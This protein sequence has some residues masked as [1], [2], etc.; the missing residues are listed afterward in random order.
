M[1]RKERKIKNMTMS[2][3]DKEDVQHMNIDMNMN[4]RTSM[5]MKE[6]TITA[7]AG[8]RR[9]PNDQVIVAP[10]HQIT[11]MNRDRLEAED[12]HTL[13]N[14]PPTALTTTSSATTTKTP[15]GTS[16]RVNN[17]NS[18]RNSGGTGACTGGDKDGGIE[19]DTDSKNVNSN[20]STNT[21]T[22]TNGNKNASANANANNSL[23]VNASKADGSNNSGP[24]SKSGLGSRNVVSSSAGSSSNSNSSSGDDKGP[25]HHNKGGMDKAGSS[26]KGGSSDKDKGSSSKPKPKVKGSKTTSQSHGYEHDNGLAH[27]HDHEH[28]HEHALYRNYTRGS[29]T[30][31][32]ETQAQLQVNANGNVNVNDEDQNPMKPLSENGSDGGY[33]G[34]A[35]SN[36]V[37]DNSSSTSDSVSSTEGRHTSKPSSLNA[38]RCRGGKESRYASSSS[39]LADFSSGASDSGDPN[40][41]EN[42]RLRERER[43]H[44]HGRRNGHENGHTHGR[45]N[46]Y[47]ISSQRVSSSSYLLVDSSSDDSASLVEGK[48]GKKRR[49]NSDRAKAPNTRTRTTPAAPVAT[50]TSMLKAVAKRRKRSSTEAETS[51]CDCDSS[52]DSKKAL[53]VG[54]KTTGLDTTR[55]RSESTEK[56]VLPRSWDFIEQRLKN[57]A[58]SL[59]D[60]QDNYQSAMKRFRDSDSNS[61][62]SSSTSNEKS[63]TP[64]YNIGVDVMAKILSYLKPMEANRVLSEPLSKTFR[65]SFSNPQDVWKILCLSEPF[66]ARVKK[67][68]DESDDSSSSYPICDNMELQHVLG[69][70]RL[71]YS[72]FVRCVTYLDRIKEDALNGNAP[73]IQ[74]TSKDTIADRPAFK[75]NSSL[76]SFFA[77]ARDTNA[78]RRVKYASSSLT[79]RLLGPVH[80]SGIVG[81]VDLPRSCAVY[82]IV[83]WM[84]AFADVA[85]IQMM[86]MHVLP[87]LLED[88][89]QRTTAQ[90]A[91]LTDIVLRAMVLFPDNAEL[92]TSAFH[93]LVLL[94]RPIGGK[95]GMIFYRAMVNASGIFN[96]GSSTGKSGIAI[97]LDSMKRFSTNENLQAMSCWSMVNIALIQSQKVA[98]VR[99]GGISAAGNAMMQHP[100]SPD[101]QFRALFALINLV[102]P[103]ENLPENSLEAEAIRE[104]VDGVNQNSETDMLD[105]TV[106]YITNLVVVAMKN[107]CSNG[108]ILNRACLVLHNLSLNVKYHNVLLWTPNCYQMIEWCIENYKQDKVLQQS[109]RGTLQRLQMTLSNDEA[110]RSKFA[111]SIRAQQQSVV[112]SVLLQSEMISRA[113]DNGGEGTA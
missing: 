82:S 80:R 78:T 94:A 63:L 31:Q 26:N 58:S 79:S 55:T 71:L 29:N 17:L 49:I 44:A 76:E 45:R 59:A 50:S 13:R 40:T 62:L 47:S 56:Y 99:L 90:N 5:N 35:S 54:T 75:G 60:L 36:D 30:I 95:E 41:N 3:I 19:V 39:E 101:V 109:A 96:I 87:I 93:T 68:F 86:C 102:I 51:D 53:T 70:Y 85:G 69:R 43:E 72:S 22:S 84:V 52:T 97:M 92:H 112:N 37:F 111:E 107:F 74:E 10:L 18:A 67:K 98:L 105:E 83:N 28:E 14:P 21:S 91:G 23:S 110:L 12:T 27:E 104:Q 6:G 11:G 8:Q 108:A 33:A 42:G 103:S 38:K 25:D 64:L 89:K 2:K 100:T 34:S 66:Y 81:N 32:E 65:S 7:A 113:S 15:K 4:V 106:E 24:S 61:N 88:D 73:S 48:A 1:K 46:N 57:K 16:K 20:G 9:D 77:R